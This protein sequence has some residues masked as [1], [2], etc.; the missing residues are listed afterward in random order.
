MIN[1]LYKL[2]YLIGGNTGY[3]RFIIL[4]GILFTILQISDLT[5]TY[6]ALQNPQNKELNPYYN[7]EWFVPFKL[8]MVLL[9]MFVMHRI[10]ASNRRLAKSAMVGMIYMYLFINFNNLYLL[11]SS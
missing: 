2:K 3:I 6:F 10:P 4:F 7:E 1:F 9:I 11:L 8:T 5:T